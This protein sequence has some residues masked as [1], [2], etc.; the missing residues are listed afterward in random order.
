MNLD[1]DALHRLVGGWQ[2][3]ETDT[4]PVM[5]P[6]VRAMAKTQL[7]GGRDVVLPQYHA[8]LDEIVEL[9]KLAHQHGGGLSRAVV[10]LDDREKAAIAR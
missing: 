1:V 6:L 3:E 7:E 2:D 4:W 9:E 10:L 5:W 8:K